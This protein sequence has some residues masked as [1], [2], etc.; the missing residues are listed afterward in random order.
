MVVAAG[1]DEV[2]VA[3]SALLS[4][5]ATSID[6]RPAGDGVL[7]YAT[8][9]NDAPAEPVVARL[10][11]AGWPA[12]VRPAGGG[13]L[14]AWLGHTRPVVIDDRLWVSFPWSEFD[15]SLA[16]LLVEVDPGRAFGTGAHPSTKLLIT[17]L[18]ERLHVGESVLDV[19]C[20]SGVLSLCAARL[21]AA[22]VAAIDV[23]EEALAVTRANAIRNDLANTIDVSDR[24]V[25]DVAGLFD[26]IL[27]NIGAATLVE[28]A[29]QLQSR[30]R[31]TGWLGLSGISPAQ[32]S[33][34]SAAYPNLRVVAVTQDDD[35]SA[36]V[37]LGPAALS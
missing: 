20:G 37:A 36:I 4:C 24:Q 17:E 7:L 13:H 34:V 21:G 12:V 26:V 6:E 16:P 9:A 2:Q 11:S 23:R 28:L 30:L 18:A 33:K 15:R 1:R 32:V 25:S 5:G 35:W 8:L 22:F 31:P 27:A 14:A 10:R 3:S 29:P 19:G